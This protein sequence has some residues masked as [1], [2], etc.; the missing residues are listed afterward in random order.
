MTQKIN[1]DKTFSDMLEELNDITGEIE[2]PIKKSREKIARAPFGWP[3]S[4]D[5]SLKEILPHL[6]YKQGYCEPF[7]GGASVLMARQRSNIEVYNDQYSGVTHFFRVLHNPAQFHQLVERL[8][9]TIHSRE[10]FVWCRETWDAPDLG[11]VER[12]ARWYYLT[13][14]SFGCLGRNFAR[15]L[16]AVA[17]NTLSF[18]IHRALPD[19]AGIK[20]RLVGVQ[21]ENMNWYDFIE[22]YDM[23]EYVMYIDPPYINGV[24]QNI[25]HWLPQFTVKDHT[26]LLDRV[27]IAKSFVAV[28]HYPNELYDSYKWD[29][30]YSWPTRTT[31]NPLVGLRERNIQTERLY[32]H[33]ER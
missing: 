21:F 19:F 3:G 17:S 32:I 20:S 7:G 31:L 12:A 15:A 25:Y 11:D 33:Y 9:Y 29:E 6:P 22:D 2:E 5:R 27:M 13:V 23:P 28:S 16:S 4:K 1:E 26:K 14:Y 10:E 18:K 30:V 24:D 8:E